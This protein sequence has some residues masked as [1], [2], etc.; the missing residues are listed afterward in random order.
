MNRREPTGGPLPNLLDG[1]DIP[2]FILDKP[3]FPWYNEIQMDKKL[4]DLEKLLVMEKPNNTDSPLELYLEVRRIKL[5]VR[6]LIRYLG[7][8]AF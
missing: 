5:V 2:V 4:E 6:E 1:I 8:S 3:Y 7:T